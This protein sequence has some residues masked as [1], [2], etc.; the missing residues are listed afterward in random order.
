MSKIGIS[1]DINVS[2]ILKERLY[3]GKQGVYL[4][5]TTFIDTEN[6]DIYGNNG[7]ISQSQT[8]EERE[9]GAERTP[10]LGNCKVFYND[11]ASNQQRSEQ[12]SAGMQQAKQ[13]ATPADD[14]EDSDI[15]F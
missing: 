6:Q 1:I 4:N 9:G 3:Q 10:I 5:L 2:K 15:P 11:N 14:F 13:A 7:F 12:H 8:K